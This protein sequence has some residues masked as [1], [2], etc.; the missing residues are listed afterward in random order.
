VERYPDTAL[1]RN[2]LGNGFLMLDPEDSEGNADAQYRK[3]MEFDPGFAPPLNNLGIVAFRKKDLDG[4]E[5]LFES[6]LDA[7]PDDALGWANLALLGAARV[8][9]DGSNRT[10]AEKAERAARRAITL[11]PEIPLG[12]KALGRLLEMTD[13]KEEALRAYQTSLLLD[14]NQSDVLGRVERLGGQP[15]APLDDMMP[16]AARRAA[17]AELTAQV[18][19]KLKDNRFE[20][21]SAM[22]QELCRCLPGNAFA[23]RLLARA[24]Q[25]QGRTSEA[26]KA[27]DEAARLL[28][29]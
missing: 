25:R 8:E 18:V 15:A 7:C 19:E 24:F 26:K 4:A 23:Y 3:A 1:L 16:R 6:Y 12:Y 27:S 20:E 14:R 22:A 9:K 11:G 17:I 13:R 21:A 2:C 28:K 10:S 29:P 5:A